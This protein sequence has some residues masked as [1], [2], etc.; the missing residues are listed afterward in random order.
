MTKKNRNTTHNKPSPEIFLEDAPSSSNQLCKEKQ[1]SAEKITDTAVVICPQKMEEPGLF[2]QEERIEEAKN[3]ISNLVDGVAKT[4]HFT[5]KKSRPATLL[6]GGQC[7]EVLEFIQ[8]HSATLVF[9]DD[10]LSG[11]QQKNLEKLFDCKVVDRTGVILDI[12]SHRARTLEGRLQVEL[13]TQEY[14]KTRLVRRWTHLERQRGGLCNI[15]GPGESQLE[16]DRRMI[17][18]KIKNLKQRLDH[19]KKVRA[20]QRSGRERHKIPT[21]A[22][23]GYTNA[24]KSTLFNRLANEEIYA[25]DQLFATLDTTMRRIKVSP[26]E[27]VFLSDTVGFISNLPHELVDAFKATLDE[28]LSANILLLVSDITSTSVNEQQ[29]AV[30]EVLDSIGVDNQRQHMLHVWNK[31]DALADEDKEHFREMART[32]KNTFLVSSHTG[33]GIEALKEYISHYIKEDSIARTY[34]LPYNQPDALSWLKKNTF[35]LKEKYLESAVQVRTLI[36]KAAHKRFSKH[37]LS[38]S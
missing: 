14:E 38:N 32:R 12:F 27:H 29:I 16:M 1:H 36:S 11:V 13:A 6:G 10:R 28:V 34:E 23:V 8:N 2:S 3:L 37:F 7:D 19:V 31:A 5:I 30:N 18:Q 35:I 9:V 25:Q 20:Q 33:E 17:D 21:V 24:G 22:L 26:Q 15:G 4:F